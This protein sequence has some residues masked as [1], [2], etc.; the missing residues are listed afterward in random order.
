MATANICSTFDIT[1]IGPADLD[2][3]KTFTAPRAFTITG[4]SASTTTAGPS[5]VIVT[6]AGAVC[7]ATAAGVQGTGVIQAL[8]VAGPAMPVGVWA[9][10]ATV[11]YGAAVTVITGNTTDNTI[12][13]HCVA[14]GLGAAITIS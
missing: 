12:I 4:I 3:V 2:V 14:S 5:T 11:A 10:T 1:I 9:A 8:A 13:L 6:N 7:T